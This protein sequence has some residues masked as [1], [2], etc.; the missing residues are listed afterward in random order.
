MQRSAVSKRKS[1]IRLIYSLSHICAGV[2]Q[3]FEKFAFFG[4][5]Y[6]EVVRFRVPPPEIP[7]H[8]FINKSHLLLT[9][10]YKACIIYPMLETIIINFAIGALYLMVGGAIVFWVLNYIVDAIDDL[11]GMSLIEIVVITTLCIAIGFAVS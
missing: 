10:E 2:K 7:F 6:G 9:R 4:G 11:R 8:I 3:N 1:I 5:N